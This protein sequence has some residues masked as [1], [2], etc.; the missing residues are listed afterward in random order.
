MSYNIFFFVL[1][2]GF[3]LELSPLNAAE[4]PQETNESIFIEEVVAKGGIT[5]QSNQGYLTVENQSNYTLQ[6]F[7]VGLF[8]SYPYQNEGSTKTHTKN[9]T[10]SKMYSKSD[11]TSKSS[12]TFG[13]FDIIGFNKNIQARLAIRGVS[14]ISFEINGVSYSIAFSENPGPKPIVKKGSTIVLTQ[15]FLDRLIK[16]KEKALNNQAATLNNNQGQPP[17]KH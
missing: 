9:C 15:A 6:G 2:S 14:N 1:I 13:K 10:S 8:C 17:I 11:I 7:N 4:K 3:L 5:Q 16:N 12:R